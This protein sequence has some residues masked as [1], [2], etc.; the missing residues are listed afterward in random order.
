MKFYRYEELR[1]DKMRIYERNFTSVKETPCG[2]WISDDDFPSSKRWVCKT[3][4]KRFAYPTKKEALE[5][6][7][8]RKL[9]QI[10]ILEYQ[11]KYAKDALQIACSMNE[12][13]VP[14]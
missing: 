6:L 5:S 1:I 4:R 2:H 12:L 8:A 10:S 13:E 11:L 7:K 14:K 9:R 3:G